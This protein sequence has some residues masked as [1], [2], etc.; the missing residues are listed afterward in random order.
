LKLNR[1]EQKALVAKHIRDLARSDRQRVMA[2]VAYAAP[3]SMIQ[4]LHEQLRDY[5][6]L[7]VADVAEINWRPLQFPLLRDNL[8]VDL[9]AELKLQL[10]ADA[11]ERLPHLLR[12]HA[13]RVMGAGKRGILWL[14]WGIFGRGDGQQSLLTRSQLSA[15]MR[16]AS[17]TLGSQC[18]DDLRLV[19]YAAIELE[20]EKHH[21]LAEHLSRQR[22]EPWGR[23]PAFWP[24]VLPPLGEVSPDHL[25]DFFV[26]GYSRC[27]AGIQEEITGRLVEKTGG[28]FD[29]ITRL[30]QAAEDGSWYDL[31]AQLRREQGVD[32]QPEDDEF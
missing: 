10:H 11:T 20:Q 29:E 17:E 12:R 9:E 24:S 32:L 23:R 1:D 7:E 15:W 28:E 27:D 8:L 19:S 22:W 18:P 26:H 14:N 13:S 6:D 3:G 30:M 4:S 21:D 5:L 2:L 25:F 16:F 31:L